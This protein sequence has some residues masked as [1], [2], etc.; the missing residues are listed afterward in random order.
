MIRD[1]IIQDYEAAIELWKSSQHIGLSFAD[2]R[3]EIEKYLLR[4]PGMSQVAVE[5]GRIVGTLLC[6][7]DGRRGYLYH[8]YVDRLY[9]RKGLGKKL[10]DACLR[11]L[12]KQGIDKCHLFIF[13]ENEA[14]K[15]FWRDTGWQERFD[16]S[17]FSRDI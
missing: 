3:D 17:V 11:G 9:R 8:L 15:Q 10:V 4:N 6:G 1:F 12:K 2:G 13:N 14:G 7:H 5:D 16:I